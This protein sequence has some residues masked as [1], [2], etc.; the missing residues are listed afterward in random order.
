MLTSNADLLRRFRD[1]QRAALEEFYWAHIRQVETIVRSGLARDGNDLEDVVQEVFVKAFAPAA[2]Q[3]YD[4]SRPWAPYVFAITRN[5]VCDRARKMGREI[6]VDTGTLELNHLAAEVDQEPH[7]DRETMAAVERFVRDLP[8]DLRAIHDKRFVE[9]LSQRDAADALG[10]G[11]Q[12]LRTLEGRLRHRLRYALELA[13]QPGSQT[14][15]AVSLANANHI[16][17]TSA[18]RR[19]IRVGAEHRPGR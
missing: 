17:K 8:S 1:G 10:I 9:G 7:A 12:T 11:R 2:R 14:A 19:G 15:A 4:G 18:A 5:V 3:V 13:G 16:E 6:P